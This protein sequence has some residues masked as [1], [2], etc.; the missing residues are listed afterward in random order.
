[1]SFELAGAMCLFCG[2]WT[3]SFVDLYRAKSSNVW[4]KDENVGGEVEVVLH[5]VLAHPH[6]SSL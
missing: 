4:G 2:V 6:I 3:T 5:I 1:M